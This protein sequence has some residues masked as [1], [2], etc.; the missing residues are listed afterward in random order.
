MHLFLK[1][2][3]MWWSLCSLVFPMRSLLLK[4]HNS[5]LREDPTSIEGHLG[6]ASLSFKKC[7]Q[8][9]WT[10][11]WFQQRM[12]SLDL[13]TGIVSHNSHRYTLP[14]SSIIFLDFSP[15][16]LQ[17]YFIV[18]QLKDLVYEGG[19]RSSWQAHEH[20]KFRLVLQLNVAIETL[21]SPCPPRWTLWTNRL[22]V[23]SQRVSPFYHDL[24]WGFAGLV[25]W[26]LLVEQ[27]LN[28]ILSSNHVSMKSLEVGVQQAGTNSIRTTFGIQ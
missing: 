23:Q 18:D 2:W 5:D 26:L 12:H 20:E 16:W 27:L 11:P 24:D 17:A 9:R 13:T 3:A 19:S 15:N 25:G 1:L 6:L 21:W 10:M 28:P 14:M 4:W 7:P 8:M 22:V